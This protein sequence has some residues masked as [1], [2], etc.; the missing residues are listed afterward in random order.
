MLGVCY[1][2]QTIAHLRNAKVLPGKREYGRAEVEL[3][4][5]DPLF[6]ITIPSKTQFY[7]AMGRPIVA[8]ATHLDEGDEFGELIDEV[9]PAPVFPCSWTSPSLVPCSAAIP[10]ARTSATC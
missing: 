6:E 4:V 7:L 10:I 8:G 1:G 5:D 3:T 9:R 2:M